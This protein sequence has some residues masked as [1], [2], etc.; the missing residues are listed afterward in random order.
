MT[1]RRG[2]GDVI[3]L[4]AIKTSSTSRTADSYLIDPDLAVTI[5]K[6]GSYAV[7]L[8]AKV[9]TTPAID[10]GLVGTASASTV[11]G[12]TQG[13]T[14]TVAVRA[15]SV[16][17]MTVATTGYAPAANTSLEIRGVVV[18]SAAGTLG[19]GWDSNDNS[20]T[21]TVVA[22]FLSVHRLG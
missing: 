12:T 8:W 6:T 21:V 22:G 1:I 5:G 9:S 15:D 19:F 17:G 2:I 13:W 16:T 20:S 4:R 18:V 14:S 10:F 7:D 3:P 11:A